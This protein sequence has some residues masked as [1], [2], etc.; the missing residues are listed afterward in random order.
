MVSSELWVDIWPIVGDS[1]N[2]V[3]THG[4]L[5]VTGVVCCFGILEPLRE[6]GL[7]LCIG[8]FGVALC[9]CVS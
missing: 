9:C 7:A 1:L 4:F 3:I 6:S 5:L 2:I 8:T